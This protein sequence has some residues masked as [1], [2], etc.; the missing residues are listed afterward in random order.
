M[1]CPLVNMFNMQ[2]ALD[3]FYE[4]FIPVRLLGKNDFPECN[5][6]ILLIHNYLAKKKRP[7]YLNNF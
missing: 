7:S 3:K 1:K 5:L 6:F 2:D 4:S